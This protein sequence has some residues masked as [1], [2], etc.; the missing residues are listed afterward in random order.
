MGE[1]RAEQVMQNFET[2]VFRALVEQSIAGIYV[3]QDNRLKYANPTLCD[4]FGYPAEDLYRLSVADLVHPE[5]RETVRRALG[6]RLG[7]HSP[8]I[9]YSFRGVRRDGAVIRVE[10]HGV[11]T[12]FQGRP[13]V[14]GLLIDVTARHTMQVELEKSESRFRHIT[15]AL[16]GIIYRFHMTADGAMSFPFI[17]PQVEDMYGVTPEDVYRDPDCMFRLIVQEDLP[18]IQ[19][20]IEQSFRDTTPWTCDWRIDRGHGVRHLRGQ[21]IPERLPDGSMQWDGVITDVTELMQTRDALRA[22]HDFTEAIIGSLPGIFYLLDGAGRVEMDNAALVAALGY[23]PQELRRMTIDR[24]IAPKDV[25]RLR[26]AIAQVHEDGL[27]QVE[28]DLRHKDGTTI[29]F[30]L[31]GRRLDTDEGPKL[32]GV[33]L[34][35]TERKRLENKLR[36]L[37]ATDPLTGLMNRRAFMEAAHAAFTLAARTG[38]PVSVVMIDA[39]HFKRINDTYGHDAGDQVLRAF[40]DLVRMGLRASDIAGRLGGEE[41]CLILPDT[42]GAATA[43]A[44]ER[45]LARVRAATVPAVQGKVSFSVSVGWQSCRPG[46]AAGALR[47]CLREADEALYMAKAAGRDQAVAASAPMDMPTA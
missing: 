1:P 18:L 2:D 34:D 35:L 26:Q 5:D 21:S 43:R 28:A 31:T 10:V 30:L 39:D 47:T 37:A 16:P 19:Q 8:S 32:V 36:H 41:F 20:S 24:L 15:S 3:I 44:V 45:L 29:P 23:T 9:R 12:D 6:A 27:A 25:G 38:R 14:S 33:G 11:V 7:G 17:S 46:D 40:A 22:K 13:A 4:M 42:E